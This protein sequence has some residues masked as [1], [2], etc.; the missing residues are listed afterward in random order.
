MTPMKMTTAGIPI[1]VAQL[2][3]LEYTE[4]AAVLSSFGEDDPKIFLTKAESLGA[5]GFLGNPL[6]LRLLHEAVSGNGKWPNTRYD[7][8]MSAV[9]RLSLDRNAEHRRLRTHAPAIG[10]IL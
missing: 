7:L 10:P 5:A 1:I 3:P 6:S 8:F 2:R 4:A 9:K